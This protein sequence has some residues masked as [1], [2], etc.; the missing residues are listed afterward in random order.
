MTVTQ[1]IDLYPE[2]EEVGLLRI[3]TGDRFHALGQYKPA[4]DWYMGLVRREPSNAK[5]ALAARKAVEGLLAGQRY[6]SAEAAATEMISLL[7]A[8]EGWLTELWAEATFH[9]L[10]NEW[11]EGRS[12]DKRAAKV[13]SEFAAELSDGRWA[14][15][16]LRKAATRYEQ[17]G[18]AS[19]AEAALK[20]AD[21]RQR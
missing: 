8:E 14:S 9:A 20:E 6:R 2:S 15:E 16:A 5:A 11:P 3:E 13:W 1:F 19:K 7:P 12:N 21:R 17:C 10:D 18:Q 4:A